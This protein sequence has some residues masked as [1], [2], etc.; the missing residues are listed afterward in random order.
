MNSQHLLLVIDKPMTRILPELYD[1]NDN[2]VLNVYN[3]N[4]ESNSN[5]M[6]KVK[7]QSDKKQ[8]PTKNSIIENHFGLT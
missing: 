3:N 1:D 7:R 4:N 5:S 2:F 8:G 6:Y